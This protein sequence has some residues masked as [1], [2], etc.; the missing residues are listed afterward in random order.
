MSASRR[1]CAAAVVAGFAAI[2][3]VALGAG[4]VRPAGASGKQFCSRTAF[5]Q[6]LPPTLDAVPID[7]A[8]PFGGLFLVAEQ[9]APRAIGPTLHRLGTILQKLA[10]AKRA[11][12]RAT[13]IG[14]QGPA[15]QG[16]FTTFSAYRAKHCPAPLPKAGGLGNV[17]G[18]SD[19]ACVSDAGVIKQA[20]ELYSTVNGEIRDHAA[21]RGRPVPQD[22]LELLQRHPDR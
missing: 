21:A 10:K 19:Q 13:L 18:A 20:E 15:Y 3:L 1:R 14:K 7:R 5:A 11:T 12:A 8:R 16:S 2:V 22:R 6:D 17:G 9:T 4:D